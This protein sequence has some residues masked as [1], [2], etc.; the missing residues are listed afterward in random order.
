[1]AAAEDG[2][3]AWADQA[4][5]NEQNDPEQDLAL[6]E[7]NDSDDNEYHRDQPEK[8]SLHCGSPFVDR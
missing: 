3:T 4:R 1:V 2:I 8:T 7:L 6:D 5:T